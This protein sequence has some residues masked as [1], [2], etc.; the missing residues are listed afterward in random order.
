MPGDAASKT[1]LALFHLKKRYFINR[2]YPLFNDIGF[3]HLESFW[4]DYNRNTLIFSQST[5]YHIDT[6]NPITLTIKDSITRKY[7]GWSNKKINYKYD[8]NTQ[9]KKNYIQEI[10]SISNRIYRID[11]VYA[12][13]S[14]LLMVVVRPPK[15]E[16]NARYID[17]WKKEESS[18]EL[19][20]DRYEVTP[21]PFFFLSR[22][23]IQPFSSSFYF[24]GS[25][26]YFIYQSFLLPPPILV[27][28]KP[29]YTFRTTNKNI[30][31]P[32]KT[33]INVTSL[34]TKH[35]W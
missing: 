21:A 25:G 11:K 13:D 17:L 22:K 15:R 9:Y 31:Q 1:S 27:A 18:W 23:E 29:F 2:R 28:I 16:D 5:S 4:I 33:R 12:L 3:S 24:E 19:I 30:N 26:S 7:P 10:V 14:N 8:V 20:L 32:L 35:A 6:Y 34:K